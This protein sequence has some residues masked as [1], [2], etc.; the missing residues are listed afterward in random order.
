[1]LPSGRTAMDWATSVYWVG[2]QT[3][4]PRFANVESRLPL[5]FN[6]MTRYSLAKEE[7]VGLFQ[8]VP[9]TRIFP[10]GWIVMPIAV[11]STPS[12]TLTKPLLPKLL[13]IEPSGLK[14]VTPIAR[15]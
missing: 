7:E 6:R 8:A 5:E 4:L 9:Q 10:S 15:W 13:S 3:N 1:M 12:L 11:A 14:R 2:S